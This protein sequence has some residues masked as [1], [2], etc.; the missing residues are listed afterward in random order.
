[1]HIVTPEKFLELYELDVSPYVVSERGYDYIRN[2]FIP[3]LMAKYLPDIE[4]VFENSEKTESPFHPLPDGSGFVLCYLRSRVSDGGITQPMH[5]PVMDNPPKFAAIINPNARDINDA[6]AR[7][8][9]KCIAFNTGLGLKLFTREAEVKDKG[10]VAR[11]TKKEVTTPL[12][13]TSDLW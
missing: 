13:V 11:T 8:G 6:I 10:T 2:A 1:M 4:L 3:M 12:A 7:A 9:V 5:Y